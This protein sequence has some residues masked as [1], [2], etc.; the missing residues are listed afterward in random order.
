[1]DAQW[2]FAPAQ[3]SKPYSCRTA[4][5]NEHFRRH[6]YHYQLFWVI[7][8]KAWGYFLTWLSRSSAHKFSKSARNGLVNFPYMHLAF[9]LDTCELIRTLT[10]LTSLRRFSAATASEDEL[11][12]KWDRCVADLILKTGRKERLN[13]TRSAYSLDIIPCRCWFWDRTGILLNDEELV[14]CIYFQ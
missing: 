1:M 14:P 2:L 3:T 11:G 7:W 12:L 9:V 8:R 6:V 10:M 13:L 5:R 4:C